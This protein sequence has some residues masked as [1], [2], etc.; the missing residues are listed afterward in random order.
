[1]PLSE[2]QGQDVNKLLA[3]QNVLRCHPSPSVRTIKC[4]IVGETFVLSGRVQS[5]HARHVAEQAVRALCEIQ[6]LKNEIRVFV[7]KKRGSGSPAY[8]RG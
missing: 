1:M 8:A 4:E 5:H 6:N 2:T 7:P 3:V